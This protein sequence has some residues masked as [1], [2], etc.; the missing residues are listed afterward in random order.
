MAYKVNVVAKRGD[1][2]IYNAT[3]R[4]EIIQGV[5]KLDCGGPYCGEGKLSDSDIALIQDAG[6]FAKI[7]LTETSPIMITY[8]F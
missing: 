8:Y 4:A 1:T 2:E 7:R 5:L 3:H 6:W